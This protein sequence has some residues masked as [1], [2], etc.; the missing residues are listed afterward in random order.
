MSREPL[1]TRPFVL[2]SLANL[3]QGLAFN[4]FLHFPGFLNELGAGEVAIGVLFG[5][6]GVTAIV[7]R[8]P[9]GRVMDGRGRRPV[10]LVGNALNVLALGLYLVVDRVG[11]TLVGIRMLH[12]LAEAMLFTA[13]FT[14]AADAVPSD[15]RTQGLALF[16]VSGMLPIALAGVLGDLVLARAGY[17]ELFATAFA[18]AVLAALLSLPLRDLPR[19]DF[20]EEPARGFRAALAQPDLRPMWWMA[21]IFAT[22]LAAVFT[23]LKRYVDETGLGSVGGFFSAYSGTAL[24]LRVFFG[25]LPDRLGPKR[26]LFP[27]LVSLATAFAVLA[28]ARTPTAVVGAGLLF[29]IGHG[30]TF[31]ILFGMV[32]TRARV[33]DRGSAMGIFTALFDVGLVVGGP[34]FGAIITL[35]GF[36]V[37]YASACAMVVTGSVVFLVW[38]A[39]RA[40]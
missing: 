36:S 24:V 15:R 11:V 5:L 12:G 6:T 1:F 34:V 26:V 23:F 13:L 25:W 10:I 17:P 3:A 38:D 22:A 8:P 21:A 18:S 32:V 33:A 16:G 37:M 27:V 35:G 2:C 14:Y 7:A 28:A 39:R 31:P 4:L 20:G 30:F 40:R 19:P 29:G 9:I